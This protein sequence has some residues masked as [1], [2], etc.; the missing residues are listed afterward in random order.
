MRL[1]RLRRRY[2][3]G[4]RHTAQ[5]LAD[6][7]TDNFADL[8]VLAKTH[9]ALGR[10][11]I[12]IDAVRRQRDKQEHR[13]VAAF[14]HHAVVSV[15]DG[16]VNA[17]GSDRPPVDEG[18]LI[19][20]RRARQP[21]ARG[22]TGDLYVVVGMVDRHHGGNGFATEQHGRARAQVA[23]ALNGQDSAVVEGQIETYLRVG[24]RQQLHDL[25]D[26][27]LLRGDTAEELLARR[28]IEEEVAYLHG[29]T[30]ST[31]GR[32]DVLDDAAG[33][34]DLGALV[35]IVRARAQLEPG[36]RGDAGQRLAAKTEGADVADICALA[37]LAGRMRFQ[38]HERVFRVHAAA[39]VDDAHQRAAAAVDLDRQAG[40]AGIESVFDQLLD[41]RGRAFDN[42]T[43][44]DAVADVFG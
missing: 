22:E 32:A 12:D 2:D 10:V 1:C 29:R 7:G 30:G 20:A 27:R 13:R 18:A 5:S 40:G 36:H 37:N 33:G 4:L 3:P 43:G 23:A 9:L 38:A 8:P 15:A 31:A 42:L 28:Q 25:L 17:A 35:G 39:V 41:D 21:G 11:H 44:R 34:I 14:H 6:A 24:E 19:A 16:E 26:V